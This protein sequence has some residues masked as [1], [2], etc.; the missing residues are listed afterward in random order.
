VTPQRVAVIREFLARGDHPSA[1]TL[2]RAV[3]PLYPMMAVS[4]VYSTV[5]LLAELGV[6]TEVAPGLT[7]ARYDPNT[8]DHCHLICKR[9]GA[10]TDVEPELD[11][12]RLRECARA[13]ATGFR[14][15]RVSLD[16]YG[17]CAACAASGP[18]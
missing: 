18:Q 7:E 2:H 11:L 8:S 14:P 13:A 1:E 3:L 6:A 16:L 12:T 4:T 5:R 17:V 10:I 15:E 9:C